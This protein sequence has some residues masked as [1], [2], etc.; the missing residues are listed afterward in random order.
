MN[1]TNNDFKLELC[2]QGEDKQYGTS[3]CSF[4]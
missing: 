1:K 3:L 4:T 2:E